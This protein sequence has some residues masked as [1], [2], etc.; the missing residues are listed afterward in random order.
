MSEVTVTFKLEADDPEDRTGVTEET[1]N[2]VTEALMSLGGYDYE[3][4]LED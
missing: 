4:E 1:Y 3:F 2:E